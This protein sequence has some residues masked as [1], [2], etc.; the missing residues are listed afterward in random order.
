MTDGSDVKIIE[1][2]EPL[3]AME[4]RAPVKPSPAKQR[5]RS[6]TRRFPVVDKVREGTYWVARIWF[7]GLFYSNSLRGRRPRALTLIPEENW[8]G[9]SDRGAGLV[10]G[11]F[12]F[13][14]HTLNAEDAFAAALQAGPAW[15]AELHGFE[16]LRDMRAV[17]TEAA[18]IQ[19]RNCVASWI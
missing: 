1:S 9:S 2:E 5:P 16:W 17:G 4:P 13:L 18:R 12:R 8:P 6:R 3:V 19:A 11:R 15:Q 10:D 7:R 14:N